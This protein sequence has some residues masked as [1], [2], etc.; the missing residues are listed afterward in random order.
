[1]QMITTLRQSP[2]LTPIPLATRCLY[3]SISTKESFSYLQLNVIPAYQLL[4]TSTLKFYQEKINVDNPWALNKSCI[5]R[6]F[7]FSNY[8]VKGVSYTLNHF[9]L[10]FLYNTCIITGHIGL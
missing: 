5:P 4:H 7:F 1:M 2:Y 3:Q 9:G 6:R 8:D 10:F